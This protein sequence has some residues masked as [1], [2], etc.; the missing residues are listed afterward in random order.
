VSL[1]QDPTNT[2][3]KKY[4]V[5]GYKDITNEPYSGV[6]NRHDF[7]TNAV[8]TTNGAGPHNLQI[9][10]MT[11]DG[12][13][14]TVLPGYW[15][16]EDIAAE[17]NLAAKLNKVYLDPK[18]SFTQKTQ[19]F[20]QMQLAHIQQHSPQMVKRSRMQGFDQQFE[21]KNRL[22]ITDTIADRAGAKFAMATTG[23]VPAN[24]FKTTD[25]IM[26]E[27]MASRPFVPYQN[28]DVASYVEYGKQKYD[29]QENMRMADGRVDPTAMRNQQEIGNP[30]VLQQLHPRRGPKTQGWNA[31]ATTSAQSSVSTWGNG[32]TWGNGGN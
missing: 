29:K 15:H 32:K 4:F 18:L 20:S 2:L 25:E 14:L 1:A 6:S 3:L 22:D 28:F 5:C 31:P 19:L 12:T 13:V 9:F 11:A 27:R 7:M 17:M 30:E 16:S 23:R 26:H 24:F 10:F 8:D 21:A